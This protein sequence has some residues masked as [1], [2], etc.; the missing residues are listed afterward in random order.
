LHQR[1]AMIFMGWTHPSAKI[2]LFDTNIW[3][4]ARW[5][6]EFLSTAF[7]G[8]MMTLCSQWNCLYHTS[9]PGF[10]EYSVGAILFVDRCHRMWKHDA[11]QAV[12][13][14]PG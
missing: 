4:T 14:I 8:I 1:L 13:S 11:A 12:Q 10:K 6:A 3:L 9:F 2:R 5:L 7:L